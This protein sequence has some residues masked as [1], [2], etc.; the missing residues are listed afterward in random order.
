MI[1]FLSFLLDDYGILP[2][3]PEYRDSLRLS[4]NYYIRSRYPLISGCFKGFCAY[5]GTYM[6]SFKDSSFPLRDHEKVIDTIR[7]N[8]MEIQEI[9][10]IERYFGTGNLTMG[11][12]VGLIREIY[13]S[14]LYSKRDIFYPSNSLSLGRYRQGTIFG[15]VLGYNFKG[16]F[17]YILVRYRNLNRDSSLSSGDTTG[18]YI[19]VPEGERGKTEVLIKSTNG[20]LSV[21]L[22]RRDM[23]G[24]Y[25]DREF[26]IR[27]FSVKVGGGFYGKELTLYGNIGYQIGN[28]KMVLGSGYYRGLY[29][30]SA[31]G[32]RGF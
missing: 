19:T 15:G 13:A 31:L 30:G 14:F 28:F 4:I 22:Y 23:V 11:F 10:I 8:K 24:A 20:K 26:L 25:V 12:E 9:A 17:S 16:W 18:W 6:G 3:F 21:K 32:F 7:A 5:V 29:F 1:I 2:H 27:R